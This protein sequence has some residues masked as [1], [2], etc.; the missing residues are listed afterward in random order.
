MVERKKERYDH[1]EV[2]AEPQVYHKVKIV[3]GYAFCTCLG[4]FNSGFPCEHTLLVA[5][6]H[7]LKFLIHQRWF[8]KYEEIMLEMAEISRNMRIEKLY[9]QVMNERKAVYT[10]FIAKTMPNIPGVT[11]VKP[12]AKKPD[13]ESED[14]SEVQDKILKVMLCTTIYKE[15]VRLIISDNPKLSPPK[16]TGGIGIGGAVTAT[17]VFARKPLMGKPIIGGKPI[18]GGFGKPKMGGIGALAV[19]PA[20]TSTAPAVSDSTPTPAPAATTTVEPVRE[21]GYNPLLE[22]EVANIEAMVADAE[23]K[24]S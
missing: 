12:K 17:G 20:A 23:E 19:K 3:K 24:A 14:E 10:D 11:D 16:K 7:K 8:T 13:E 15:D 21:I 4:Y 5:I 2:L 1:E 18:M 22:L 9:E 6:K